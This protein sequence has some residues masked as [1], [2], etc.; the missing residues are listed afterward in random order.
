MK[1]YY[2]EKEAKKKQ[3]NELNNDFSYLINYS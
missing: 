2:N 3:K 1:V